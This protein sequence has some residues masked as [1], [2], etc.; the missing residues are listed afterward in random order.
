MEKADTKRSIFKSIGKLAAVVALAALLLSAVTY[1]YPKNIGDKTVTVIVKQGDSFTS[2]VGKLVDG[3]VMSS[4]VM[5]KIPARIF[6]FDKR[7]VPGR[8][9]FTGKNSSSS[10]LKKRW[11]GSFVRLTC[12]IPECSNTDLPAAVPVATA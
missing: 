9:D 7:L 12:T 2:V 11:R 1:Y 4:K 8:Y 5:L 3:G 6:G 10:V